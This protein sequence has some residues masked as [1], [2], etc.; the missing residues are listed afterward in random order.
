MYVCI[1]ITHIKERGLCVVF[2][3]FVSFIRLLYVFSLLSASIVAILTKYNVYE[4]PQIFMFA[5][6]NEERETTTT[7]VQIMNRNNFVWHYNILTISILASV[8]AVAHLTP[9]TYG[10]I[11]NNV[12]IFTLPTESNAVRGLVQRRTEKNN[13]IQVQISHTSLQMSFRCLYAK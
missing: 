4:R 9:R 12:H 13:K 8:I 1:L 11:C 10:S 5:K 6:A 3:I 7:T 2:D